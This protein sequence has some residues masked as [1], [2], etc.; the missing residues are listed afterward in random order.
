[1]FS[2]LESNWLS[3]YCVYNHKIKLKKELTFGYT[4]LYKQSTKELKAVK[5]YLLDNLNQGFITISKYP[6]A[7]LVLFVKKPN[8]SLWFCINY[9]KLNALTR[10]DLYLI[11]YINELLFYILKVKVFTKLDIQEAFY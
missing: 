9:R 7:L 1:V 4:L 2:K 3:L 10:K 11:L 8:G 6:F 5:Q